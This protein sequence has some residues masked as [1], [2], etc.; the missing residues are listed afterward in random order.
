MYTLEGCKVI[1]RDIEMVERL[2]PRSHLAHRHVTVTFLIKVVEIHLSNGPSHKV[3]L[4][5]VG[6]TL[7]TSSPV[8][9][10]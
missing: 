5:P 9:Q 1:K 3:L 8:C 2:P 10:S 6:L 7:H 4:L